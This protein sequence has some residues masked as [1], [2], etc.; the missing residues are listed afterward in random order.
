MTYDRALVPRKK[1]ATTTP[2]EIGID[3]T[4]GPVSGSSI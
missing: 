2:Q 3:N 4:T 1:T